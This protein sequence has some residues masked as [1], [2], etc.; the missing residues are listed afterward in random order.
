MFDDKYARFYNELNSGKD[1]KGETKFV[2]EWAEKPKSILDIGCGTAD[3]WEYYPKKVFMAGI[4]ASVSMSSHSK[5]RDRIFQ[6]DVQR[7]S[8]GMKKY[9][10]V[11]AIFDVMNYIQSHRWWNKLPVK[12]GG[13]FIFDIFDKE[14]VDREKFSTTIKEMKYATRIIKPLFYDGRKVKLFV[15]LIGKYDLAFGVKEQH[16]MRIWSEKEIRKFAEPYFEVV[17]VKKTDRWQTWYKL[18]R[19]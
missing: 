2:Y 19:K 17:E 5:F 13:Y 6:A 11:T 3:Y 12:S 18:V 10:C 7:C 15:Y 9:D 8:F 14:K 4:E 1:Y 16:I